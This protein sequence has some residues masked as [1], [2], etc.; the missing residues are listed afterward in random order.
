MGALV[1]SATTIVW[2]W[3]NGSMGGGRGQEKRPLL[4]FQ[5][6]CLTTVH[7]KT[8]Q[9]SHAAQRRLSVTRRPLRTNRGIR[10]KSIINIRVYSGVPGP[11]AVNGA[12][13]TTKHSYG[14]S[15]WL[16][17]RL[18][19]YCRCSVWICWRIR[20]NDQSQ[21]KSLESW[22]QIKRKAIISAFLFSFSKKK[23]LIAWRLRNNSGL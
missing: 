5:L 13:K 17:T 2:N 16:A 19:S 3:L 1:P 8:K 23:Y 11:R 7:T 12:T 15:N 18:W 4:S 20:W 6:Y 14:I 10:H 9:P 22:P 21:L